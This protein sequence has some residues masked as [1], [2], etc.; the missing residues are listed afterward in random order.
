MQPETNKQFFSKT[1]G[2]NVHIGGVWGIFVLAAQCS[3][4]FSEASRA[5]SGERASPAHLGLDP[6]NNKEMRRRQNMLCRSIPVH[7]PEICF[8]WTQ[9]CP[10]QNHVIRAA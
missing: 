8:G 6:Q 5:P 4:L 9:D 1:N 3:A 2:L 7:P 10:K